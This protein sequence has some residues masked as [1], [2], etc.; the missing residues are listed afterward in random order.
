LTE[1]FRAIVRQPWGFVTEHRLVFHA[2]FS[3]RLFPA[4]ETRLR[5]IDRSLDEI[6]ALPGVRSATVTAPAPMD[7]SWDT[8]PL[9]PEGSHPPEPSGVFYAYLRATGP[10]YFATMG[11]RL[12]QGREFSAD[13]RPGQPPVCIVNEAFA[14]RFWPNE[15]PIGKRIKEGRLDGTRPWFTF[16]G[17]T[18][19]TK[20]VADPGDGEVVGAFYVS[21]PQ[22]VANGFDEM[23]F[24]VETTGP[25]RALASDVRSALARADNRLA[26]FNVGTLEEAAADSWVTERFLFVLVSL[27]GV[28]GLVLAAIGVYGLLALQV[29]RRTREFGVRVALG[30]TR[31]A[32]VRLVATQGARLLA[33]G[34][35]AGALGAWAGVRILQ[36][37]WPGVPA[38]DPRI[39]LGAATVL[40]LGVVLASWLPA[41]RAGRTDPV[42]ALRAE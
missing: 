16:V 2:T 10:G 29:A 13:D 40:S 1:Y 11:Q 34:F 25:P 18:N 8:I 3:D 23:T 38:G 33:L 20:A 30:A 6:R 31:R 37:Q 27:F 21:L 36:H 24:V 41:R 5:A 19:D 26:A 12:V 9:A 28:L 42:I 4:P 22:A 7:A 14:R 17:P 32:L 39:W 35:A 15:N